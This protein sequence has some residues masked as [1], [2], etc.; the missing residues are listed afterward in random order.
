MT[1]VALLFA[2]TLLF[3]AVPPV[4]A[5]CFCGPQ[6][7]SASIGG[8]ASTCSELTSYLRSDSVTGANFFCSEM[9]FSSSCNVT[10]PQLGPCTSAGSGR[11]TMSGTY[12]YRCRACTDPI[13]HPP[14]EQ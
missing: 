12:T 1:R 6:I 8:T 13:D 14:H 11:V 10:E 9:G 3:L 7:Y 2:L 4:H 5:G